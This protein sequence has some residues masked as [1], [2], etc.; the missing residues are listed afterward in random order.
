MARLRHVLFGVLI[1]VVSVSAG[2]DS[3]ASPTRGNTGQWNGVDV[4][5]VDGTWIGTEHPCN[6]GASDRDRPQSV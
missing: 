5:V 6:G 3:E 4:H 2:C 1:G